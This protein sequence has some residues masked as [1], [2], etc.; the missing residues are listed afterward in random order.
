MFPPEAITFLKGLEKHNTRDWFQP[1]KEIFDTKLKEPMLAFVEAINGELLKFAPEHI[2]EPKKAVYRIYRDTRFSKDKTPYKTHL[3]AIFPRRGLGK[4]A[5]AGFYFHVSS[6]G[7]G[8]ACGAYAPGPEQLL[9]V[10]RHIAENHKLLR[11]EIK[12][13]GSLQ[14]STLTR[15]PKGFDAEHPAA[16]LIKM[17]QWYWWVELDLALATS[18]KLKGEI[19]KRFR[20]VAPMVE[21]LNRPLMGKAR[22]VVVA[23]Q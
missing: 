21:F 8:V 14:G 15:V 23:E 5:A 13:M 2:T 20:A 22:G 3:G 18:P 12:G 19:A 11:R 7:V 9:K 16:E 6:K 17:K 4:D 1:R 10:R